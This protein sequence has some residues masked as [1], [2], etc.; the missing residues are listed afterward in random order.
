MFKLL[1]EYLQVKYLIILLLESQ[2]AITCTLI[3]SSIDLKGPMY[4]QAIYKVLA[5]TTLY[6]VFLF[7]SIILPFIA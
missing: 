6:P 4:I 7:A 2:P 3:S 5:L 1:Y